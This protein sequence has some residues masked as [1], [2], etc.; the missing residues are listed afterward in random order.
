MCPPRCSTGTPISYLNLEW[1]EAAQRVMAPPESRSV[2]HSRTAHKASRKV[3]LRG[4]GSKTT[5]SHPRLL[6]PTH[7]NALCR[8]PCMRLSSVVALQ[9]RAGSK[10]KYPQNMWSIQLCQLCSSSSKL[11]YTQLSLY[12]NQY[13][14]YRK[15][16]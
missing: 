3:V 16:L 13:V 7:F 12:L 9:K 4:S 10:R 6:L 1:G 2:T 5:A 8:L 15:V 14:V 11:L